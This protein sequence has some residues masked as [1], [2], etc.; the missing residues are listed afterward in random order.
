MRVDITGS[1][2]RKV[3]FNFLSD[4]GAQPARLSLGADVGEPRRQLCLRN[5]A[6]LLP[7]EGVKQLP[8]SCQAVVKQLSNSGHTVAIQ[9]P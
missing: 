7:V 8:N 5:S 2:K 4:K 6:P 9:L 1:N 3:L